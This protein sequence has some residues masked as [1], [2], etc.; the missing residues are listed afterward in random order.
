[1]S[2]RKPEFQS[3]WPTVA[4][5]ELEQPVRQAFEVRMQAVTRYASGESLTQIEALTGVN[6]RQLYRMLERGMLPHPDGRP[7]GFRALISYARIAEYVRL[8]P[9]H[10]RGT[11]ER[12]TL[13]PAM[14]QCLTRWSRQFV[15]AT[16]MRST[17]CLRNESMPCGRNS[18]NSASSPRNRLTSA[19]RSSTKP[20]RMRCSTSMLCWAGDFTGTK[21]IEGRLAASQIASAS[22]ASFFT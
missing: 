20:V 9:V 2:R 7:Y 16:S 8:N 5:T 18:P 12:L 13:R 15:V 19:V 3:A 11:R 4:H 21:R 22:R 6:C 14:H 17:S 10:V 1:M